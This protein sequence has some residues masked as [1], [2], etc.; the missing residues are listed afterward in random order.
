MTRRHQ[1]H[2]LIYGAALIAFLFIGLLG[3]MLRNTFSELQP[4]I[5]PVGVSVEVSYSGGI[6]W[7]HETR[8][9]KGSTTESI[10]VQRHIHPY[11]SGSH[12]Y[13]IE[14]GFIGADSS[15][16]ALKVDGSFTVKRTF[17]LPFG[18]QDTW[19]SGADI[20]WYPVL[21]LRAHRLETEDVCFTLRTP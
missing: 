10:Q 14:G 18:A 20:V 12:G 7:L 16:E 11:N 2:F 1:A 3:L 4:P 21:S 13:I 15:S 5:M 6:A 9:Y 17:A 19:C 8:H